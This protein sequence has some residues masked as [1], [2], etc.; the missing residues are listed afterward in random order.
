VGQDRLGDGL[1]ERRGYDVTGQPGRANPAPRSE[2]PKIV[3]FGDSLTSGV[4]VPGEESYPGQ[5]QRLLDAH[6]YDY[7]VVNAGVGG[8]TTA[9]GVRR[10]DWVLKS[11][12][13]IVILEL[14][15]N[16]GLRGLDL[17]RMRSNLEYII[18]RLQAA[19]VTVVLAGMK[20]PSNYGEDYTRRFESIFP[21]L[22]RQ[23]SLILIP[24]FLEG[25]AAQ[26]NLNLADGI[27]PTGAGYKMISQ[28]LLPILEPLLG[29]QG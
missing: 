17:D 21:D 16:D 2:R 9:G 25:V 10:V 27:H 18:Q 19:H 24:F 22:A 29:K 4:G 12:P 26:P 20:I 13:Q 8:E 3:A 11:R 5:L 23:Y 15:A 14:G 28:R 6:G 7:Q 1:G